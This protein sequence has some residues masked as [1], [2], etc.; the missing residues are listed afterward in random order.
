MADDDTHAGVP[1]AAAQNNRGL[2]LLLLWGGD[3]SGA[4]ETLPAQSSAVAFDPEPLA[5]GIA[6]A[7]CEAD[8][9]KARD[10]SAVLV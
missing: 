9:Q 5:V 2:A 3:G 4:A 10:L 7:V 8:R 1:V 6:G